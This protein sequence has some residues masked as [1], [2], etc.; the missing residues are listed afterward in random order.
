MPFALG[1]LNPFTP[2]TSLSPCTPVPFGLSPL[3]PM[4][5]SALY[6]STPTPV[7]G[8]PIPPKLE[9]ATP[10]PVR[11][12]LPSTA[13]PSPTKDSTPFP[14]ARLAATTPLPFGEK[15][16][17]N[18]PEASRLWASTPLLSSLRAIT[19]GF[20]TLWP[21]TPAGSLPKKKGVPAGSWPLVPNTPIPLSESPHTPTETGFPLPSP[22]SIPLLPTSNPSTLATLFSFR[23]AAK[24][25]AAYVT[26]LRRPL[27]PRPFLRPY[28]L[29][30]NSGQ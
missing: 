1:G 8:C 25:I 17:L 3:T 21:T 22:G 7:A 11:R 28:L 27:S 9:P 13:A 15:L 2:T 12:L 18:T 6:P 10:V 16:T 24:Y 19:P 4:P 20:W 23:Q 26:R 29:E 14:P 5:V 30:V